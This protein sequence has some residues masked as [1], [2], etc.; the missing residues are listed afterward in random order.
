MEKQ[1]KMLI[2]MTDA[3][4]HIEEQPQRPPIGK[5]AQTH[6]VEVEQVAIQQQDMFKDIIMEALELVEQ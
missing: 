1:D 2:F 6:Q 5:I 3:S 4:T